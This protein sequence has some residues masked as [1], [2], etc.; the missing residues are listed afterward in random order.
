MIRKNDKI[1]RLTKG[2]HNKLKKNEAYF[3]SLESKPCIGCVDIDNEQLTFD[4][5]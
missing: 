1:D 3:N 2:R 4:T 5:L